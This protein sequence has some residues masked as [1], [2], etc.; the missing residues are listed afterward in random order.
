VSCV[1]L[2]GGATGPTFEAL[3]AE[4]GLH[5]IPAPIAGTTRIA[6]TVFEVQSG[7]EYRFTPP[8]PEVSEAEWSACLD[9][10]D[11]IDVDWLIASGSL[12]QGVPT[13]FYARLAERT[14][15]QGTR[16]VLDSSGEA[17]R[18]GISGGGV[19]IAKPNL[20]EFEQLTGRSF[21][22]PQEIGESARE[23]VSASDMTALV[24]TIGG[25]GAVLATADTFEFCPALACEAKSAVGAGDSFV[26]GMVHALANGDDLADA[27]RVGMAAGSAAILT[28]GTDLALRDDIERLTKVYAGA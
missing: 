28:A 12:P 4:H 8:G 5:A 24:V 25:D 10:L 13:D 11:R 3:V 20:A 9:K 6:T 17:L 21:D 23:L 2:A 19:Y 14:A 16:L 1:Y 26:A 27:F 7:Q 18:A 22:G 15:R